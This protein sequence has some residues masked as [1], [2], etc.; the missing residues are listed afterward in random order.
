MTKLQPNYSWQKYEG[1]PEDELEQFQKRLQSNH[2]IIANAINTTIDDLCYWQRER[3]TAFTWVDQTPI[4]TQT[5]PTVAWTAG[6]TVNV[7]PLGITFDPPLTGFVIREI[8]ATISDGTLA[9]SNTI[10]LPHIDPSVL[11]NSISIVRNGQNIVITSGGT[12]YSAFSGFVTIYYTKN[13]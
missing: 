4:Y 1:K 3:L 13:R 2:I 12:N 7:I 6:G 8:N 9:T 10:S 11:A 5:Y